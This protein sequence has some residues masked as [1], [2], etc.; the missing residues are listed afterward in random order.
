MPALATAVFHD[1]SLRRWFLITQQDWP[2]AEDLEP[3]ELVWGC[4]VDSAAGTH[5]FG[6]LDYRDLLEWH[7]LEG[8]T[9]CPAG[10]L[11]RLLRRAPPI[12]VGNGRLDLEIHGQ[13]PT[14]LTRI[15][16]NKP[17]VRK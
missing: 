17:K 4:L 5:T 11:V 2:V 1:E 3:V 6:F 12:S 13:E 10:P 14:R 15:T 8:F 9:P 16:E 7:R